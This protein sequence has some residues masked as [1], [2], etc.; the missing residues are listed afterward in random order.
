VPPSTTTEGLYRALAA[1]DIDHGF[2][3]VNALDRVVHRGARR[4]R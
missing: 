3:K 1:A 2:D 4:S